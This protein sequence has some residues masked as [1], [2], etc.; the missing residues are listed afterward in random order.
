M[1]NVHNGRNKTIMIEVD[2]IFFILNQTVKLL[3][4][5]VT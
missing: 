1:Y 3:M 5:E 2:F 4:K